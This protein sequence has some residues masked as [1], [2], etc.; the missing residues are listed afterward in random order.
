VN[1]DIKF[2]TDNS[3]YMSALITAGKR[4]TCCLVWFVLRFRFVWVCASC[5]RW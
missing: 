5:A 1:R 4:Q 2:Q 3:W